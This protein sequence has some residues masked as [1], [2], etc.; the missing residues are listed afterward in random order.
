[1]RGRLLGVVGAAVVFG[2]VAAWVKDPGS[3]GL[4]EAAQVRGALG[5]LSAPWLLLAFAAGST[6]RRVGAGAAAGLVATTAALVAF[7]VANA[8]VVD[9]GHHGLAADLRLE[10][11]GNR[12]YLAAGLLS[13][14][15]FGAVGV[16]M[17]RTGSLRLSIIAGSLMLCEPVAL[18]ALG[19][20]PVPASVPLLAGWSV[21]SGTSQPQLLVYA[22]EAVGGL[23][24]VAYGLRVVPRATRRAG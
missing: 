21:G 15:V 8:L 20:V 19:A 3:S 22:A 1:V 11:A 7:Y 2:L 9:L 5:N 24:L 16:W 23:A 10:L 4:G 18:A 17:R 6:A 13:G 12:Y 14:P